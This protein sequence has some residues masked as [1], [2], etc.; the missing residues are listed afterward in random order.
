MPNMIQYETRAHHGD[1]TPVP[2]TPFFIESTVLSA[3]GVTEMLLQ[4]QYGELEFLPA[5]PSSWQSGNIKG[6]RGRNA[7]TVDIGWKDGKLERATIKSDNGGTY[8]LRYGEK[9]RKI[10]LAKSE[11]IIVNENLK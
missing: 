10:N 2:E 5:L 9:T 4:S 7:C 6:I 11:T 3:G 1:K 8:I